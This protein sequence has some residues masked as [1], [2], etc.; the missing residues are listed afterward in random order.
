MVD[1]RC[2]GELGVVSSVMVVTQGGHPMLVPSSF[3][4]RSVLSKRILS[5]SFSVYLGLCFGFGLLAGVILL[6]SGLVVLGVGCVGVGGCVFGVSGGAV[7]RRL[8]FFRRPVF[9][10]FVPN[11]ELV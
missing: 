11:L 5:S 9:L 2:G 3:Q 10:N 4:V 6:L 7:F 8:V 1:V